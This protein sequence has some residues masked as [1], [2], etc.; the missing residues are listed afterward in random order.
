MRHRVSKAC[1]DFRDKQSS[2]DQDPS[3][4]F[5]APALLI[6]PPQRLGVAQSLVLCGGTQ[7]G[8]EIFLERKPTIEEE[9]YNSVWEVSV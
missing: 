8:S 7:R 5:M 9:K 1:V 3:L 4:R 2:L 6:I